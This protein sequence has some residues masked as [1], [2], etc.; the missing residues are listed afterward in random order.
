MKKSDI[1]L[2]S[3]STRKRKKIETDD[4]KGKNKK[5]KIQTLS[6]ETLE[7]GGD[8]SAE[9][10]RS[11]TSLKS[12]SISKRKNNGSKDEKGKKKKNR[13]K[14]KG[15]YMVNLS[16][17]RFGRFVRRKK[18]TNQSCVNDS[19]PQWEV[20]KH[21]KAV[22]EGDR[23]NLQQ[24]LFTGD[25]DFL[26]TYNN[27]QVQAKHLENKVIVLHFVPL[28]PWSEYW[29]RFETTILLDVYN[30][31]LPKGDFEVV[32]IG[33]QLD[34][35]SAAS[36]CPTPRECFENKFSIMPWI[37]IPF[38]DVKSRTDWETV[39]PLSGF[40][41][42]DT[43]ASF[44]IDHT[45]M[46]LQCNAKDIFHMYGA[47]AYPFTDKRIKCLLKEDAEARN[48]PSITKLLASSERNH[49]INKDN[50]A[51]PIHNLEDKVVGIYFYEDYPNHALTSEIQKAYEQLA[52]KNNFEIV[53]VYVHDSF[54]TCERTSEKSYWKTLKKMPWLA[55]PF[56]DP[57]C[58]KLQRVFDYPLYTCE[59]EDGPDHSLVII[60]P[61][62]KFVERYGA[63]ILKNYGIA[64][65][66]F[67]QKGVAKLEAERI[68]E[69][70]L[71]MFWSRKTTLIQKNG[72]T[73]QLS[74]LEGKRI[75]VIV[76]DDQHIPDAKFW[77]ML[78]ARYLQVK[79]TGNEFEVV[80]ICKNKERHSYGKNIAP[81]SWLRHPSRHPSHRYGLNVLE[82]F[83]RVFRRGSVVG[84]LAF[85]RDGRL[86][87][88]TPYPSI[89]KENVDF[90]FGVM[91][92]EFL[93]ELVD[94]ELEY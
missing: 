62:G 28:V 39:F 86:V 38:S 51:V 94:R 75:I 9:A 91:E 20:E 48:H 21:P 24:L 16:A 56:Q 26:I 1:S 70:K 66:P 3:C 54:A 8:E 4:E 10:I 27:R 6:H 53:L 68:K 74:Q 83:T 57:V 23:V 63:D 43:P 34:T 78:R 40:L 55:L 22:R 90:P 17:L 12:C 82:I 13:K 79:G 31:L 76:E 45:G 93:R 29:M 84:L 14:K 18:K 49:L 30:A 61:Q 47:R 89:V 72:S 11:D 60:G 85:D 41:T 64:A 92:E 88:R 32:F 37:G 5:V 15:S 52:Q 71:D 77:R 69:L 19:G 73:V 81:I 80:H 35:A 25:R 42:R 33:V 58:K 46:V 50:Q 2:R 44:V 65:Y 36:N 87:R 67:T 7:Q 59:D